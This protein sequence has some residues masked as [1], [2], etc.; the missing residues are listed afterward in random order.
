MDRIARQHRA[1]ATGRSRRLRPADFAR[2]SAALCVAIL[3]G[4]CGGGGGGGIEAIAPPPAPQ[5]PGP[6][7]SG[8]FLD[9][10]VQG[11]DFVAGAQQGTTDAR[12][13]YTCE[14]GGQVSFQV[15]AVVIGS[16]ECTTLVMP[17]SLV[18]GGA[19]DDPV[20]VNIAR[21]LQMLDQ[22]GNPDNGILISEAV[23]GMAGTWSAV[24]F[25][26]TDFAAEVVNIQSDAASVDGTPHPLPDAATAGQRLESALACA[27]AGA[28]AGPMGG[29]L[30]G[31][32]TMTV[33]F[34]GN[35]SFGFLPNQF[36]WEGFDPN[37]EF[38]LGGGSPDVVLSARP[39]IDTTGD[40]TLAGPVDAAYQTPDRIT[41]SW[42]FP[43][44]NLGGTFDLGRL[45][46]N[47]GTLKLFGSFFGGADAEGVIG[48]TVDG[49]TGD[50]TGE[51]LE[52]FSG[53]RFQITGRLDGSALGFTATD[54]TESAEFTGSVTT[55]RGLPVVD[56]TWSSP[57][58]G[59]SGT[60]DL[61]G[62]ALN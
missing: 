10:S 57:S 30:S 27:Y 44:E 37:E 56:G 33:G 62:C 45:G 31:A 23:R 26:A 58:D 17:P 19:L 20:A 40:P 18:P 47:S 29:D 7:Q 28:F 15:G 22:D 54:G 46:D 14:T 43:P 48:L 59:L 6:L 61:V 11:L 9:A 8:R 3:L 36:G 25:A 34:G 35:A 55:V 42:A 2:F 51:G 60:F 1:S 39:T 24:D 53:D 5:S 50:L 16:A 52:R 12:G 38:F 13:A 21:F 41:G 49:A 32:I 4:A